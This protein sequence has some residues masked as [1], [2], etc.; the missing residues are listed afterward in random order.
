MQSST[1][2]TAVG[3][4]GRRAGVGA[5]DQWV[6][7]GDWELGDHMNELCFDHYICDCQSENPTCSHTNSRG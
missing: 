2:I 3:K 4:T 1:L 5:V 6:K 7:P